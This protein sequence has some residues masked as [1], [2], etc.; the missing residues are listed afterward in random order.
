MH[1]SP[2]LIEIG[3]LGSWVHLGS[4]IC[5]RTR[6]RPRQGDDFAYCVGC[7]QLHGYGV[8]L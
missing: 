1:M 2:P 8:Y 3:K 6:T 4:R 5:L 7:N